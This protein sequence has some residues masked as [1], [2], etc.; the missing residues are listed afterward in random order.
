MSAT[1]SHQV[2]FRQVVLLVGLG[3]TLAAFAQAP[4]PQEFAF[5][6]PLEMPASASVAR[7]DMPAAALARLQSADARDVRIFNSAGE[8]VPF[9]IAPPPAPAAQPASSTPAFAALPLYAA[10]GGEAKSKRGAMQVRIEDAQRSVWVQIDGQQPAAGATKMDSVIFDT[11]GQKQQLSALKV[12]AGLPA[13]AP[14]RMAVSTSS[15]LARWIPAP[16]RGRLFRFEGTGAPANDV[17]EFEQPAA[18]EGRYLRLDWSGQ[19]GVTVASVTGTIATASAPVRI[20]AALPAFQP[21]SKGL[22]VQLPFATPMAAL[23]LTT[24]QANTLLPVRIL[25][26]N[27][28]SQPWRQL[29]STVVYRLGVV[30]N[31][32]TNPPVTLQRGSMRWLR[33]ESTQGADLSGT[34]LDASAEFAPVRLVFVAN[35]SAPFQLAAGRADTPRAALAVSVLAS[36]LGGKKI[37]ELPEAVVGAGTL[38]PGPEAATGLAAVIQQAG[39]SQRTALLWAVLI[40]GVLLLG[41]VAWSLMRQLKTAPPPVE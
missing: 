32:T 24:A 34:K 11:R 6:A 40:A 18:L 29:A 16:V 5:R 17:L 14:V 2:F 35:G 9:A 38:A 22:E 33:V 23:A 10:S 31:D 28:V 15:D 21:Q 13:N 1:K 4:Q 8:A 3:W 41:G 36:T 37:D 26:R 12:Q 30:G 7:A 39:I 19:E 25:G 27:E 20:R